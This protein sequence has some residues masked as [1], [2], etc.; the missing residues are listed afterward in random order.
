MM[1]LRKAESI[2]GYEI[3]RLAIDE[4]KGV[5]F[6]ALDR[7]ER[8]TAIGGKDEADA[9]EKLVD[10]VYKIHCEIVRRRQQFRCSGCSKLVGLSVHHRIFRSHGRDDRLSNL[11]ALCN[12]CHERQHKSKEK[13]GGI[14]QAGTQLPGEL[15]P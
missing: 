10:A 5:Y 7:G 1:T 13:H 15:L 12:D 8:V 4:Q 9:L 11:T 14:N 6:E 2:T 3:Q